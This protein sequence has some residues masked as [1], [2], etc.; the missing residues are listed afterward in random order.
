MR[1][2]FL[3]TYGRDRTTSG[4][5]LSSPRLVG[6]GEDGICFSRVSMSVERVEGG[7]EVVVFFFFLWGGMG[8]IQNRDK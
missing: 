3:P 6:S 5:S 4:M 8:F 1:A 2:D 7:E